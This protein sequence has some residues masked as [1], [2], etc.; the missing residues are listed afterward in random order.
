MVGEAPARAR[1]TAALTRRNQGDHPQISQITLTGRAT[2]SESDEDEDEDEDEVAEAEP[3]GP[4][5][6]FAHYADRKAASGP[7]VPQEKGT[8]RRSSW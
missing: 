3:E 8:A 6:D 5:A 2:E 4:T 7:S 1:C